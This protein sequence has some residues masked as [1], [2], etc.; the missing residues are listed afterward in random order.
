MLHA[1]DPSHRNT[2]R[3]LARSEKCLPQFYAF[4]TFGYEYLGFAGAASSKLRLARRFGSAISRL[5]PLTVRGSLSGEDWIK[6]SGLSEEKVEYRVS[7]I[8][9]RK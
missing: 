1:G 9:Q 8:V 4:T 3:I 7:L 5:K 6:I 2:V